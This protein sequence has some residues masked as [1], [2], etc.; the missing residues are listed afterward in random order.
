MT[1]PRLGTDAVHNDAHGVETPGNALP[2]VHVSSTPVR[3]VKVIWR[4]AIAPF[5]LAASSCL[6]LYGV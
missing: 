5:S 1:D 3:L 2:P 6:A 4:F